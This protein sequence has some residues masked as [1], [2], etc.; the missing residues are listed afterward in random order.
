MRM[1]MPDDAARFATWVEPHVNAM[2]RAAQA[3]APPANAEDAVQ[4]ALIRAWRHRRSFDPTRGTARAWLV[5]IASRQALSLRAR[6][7][8]K[9]LVLAASDHGEDVVADVDLRRCIRGLPRRQREAVVWHYYVDLSVN[10][11]A[12]IMRIAPG[13]VKSTLSDARESLARKLREREYDGN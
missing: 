7:R 2:L 5:A 10:E 11:I 3:V 9:S 4:E 12:A 13:T 1:D 6:A 8:P